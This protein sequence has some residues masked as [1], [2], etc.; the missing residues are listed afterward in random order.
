M[1]K[2]KVCLVVVVALAAF[3]L[4]ACD[5]ADM[6]NGQ[7]YYC[8][9]KSYIDIVQVEPLQV[10]FTCSTGKVP[11]YELNFGG[12]SDNDL[13]QALRDHN[14]SPW[15]YGVVLNKDNQIIQFYEKSWGV[16][17]NHWQAK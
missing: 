1:S 16:Y 10:R 17:V 3:L 9:S 7:N 8:T 2:T 4:A 12:P 14:Q 11:G 6:T 5:S 15:G 13:I